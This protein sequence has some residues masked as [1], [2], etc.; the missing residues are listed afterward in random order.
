M[1]PVNTTQRTS[2]SFFPGD[3]NHESKGFLKKEKKKKKKTKHKKKICR[4]HKLQKECDKWTQTVCLVSI[5]AVIL[6][7]VFYFIPKV[8]ANYVS[9]VEASAVLKA[10]RKLEE[11]YHQLHVLQKWN[12]SSDVIVLTLRENFERKHGKYITE[13][14]RYNHETYCQHHAYDYAAFDVGIERNREAHYSKIPMIQAF[15]FV[16]NYKYA[17]WTDYDALFMNFSMSVHDIF[18]MAGGGKRVGQNFSMI[19]SQGQKY[20][21]NS[22]H[23][24]F[25]NTDW[26]KQFLEDVWKVYPHPGIIFRDQGSMSVIIHG[27]NP[28][29]RKSWL[30]KNV[31]K[32]KNVAKISKFVHPK[33]HDHIW[34]FPYPLMNSLPSMWPEQGGVFVHIAGFRPRNKAACID[35][36]LW[37][38]RERSYSWY[39]PGDRRYEPYP[40]E[41]DTLELKNPLK[42][43]SWEDVWDKQGW[44]GHDH[45]SGKKK[46]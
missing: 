32:K 15:L 39:P 3:Q 30:P 45:S 1:F 25:R 23:M 20:W 24:L 26:T 31:M 42:S 2:K 17:F 28:D 6:T 38:L 21:Q 19:G 41:C 46:K 40:E 10:D 27:M 34:L 8:I 12:R 29:R 5:L 37:K 9:T 22:G 18:E 7:S 44:K 11:G 14:I 13:R 43:H 36:T 4:L 35:F 16:H 33:N